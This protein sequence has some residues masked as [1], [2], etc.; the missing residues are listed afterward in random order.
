MHFFLYIFLVGRAHPPEPVPLFPHSEK[1][2]GHAVSSV[3]HSQ[4]MPCPDIRW[5]RQVLSVF[6]KVSVEFQKY[7]KGVDWAFKIPAGRFP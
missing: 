7:G 1:L 6:A 2:V 5:S 4:L 3:T